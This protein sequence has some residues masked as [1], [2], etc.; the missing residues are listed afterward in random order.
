MQFAD[1]DSLA[2]TQA[3]HVDVQAF[4]D[5]GINSFYFQFTYGCSQTTTSFH[6]FSQTVQFDG[7]FHHDGLRVGD[8][9][10][11]HVQYVIF[12]GVELN[13]F[14]NGFALFAVD[15]QV[16]GIDVRRINQIAQFVVCYGEGQC[17]W[18]T[19][20]VFCFSI[21]VT[22]YGVSF[23]DFTRSLFAE[24]SSCCTFYINFFHYINF[25]VLL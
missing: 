6:T 24:C 4:G 9:I 5:I 14:Q 23:T 20:F 10:K 11:I 18:C 17:D 13:F 3:R 1:F 25:F 21:Q 2:Q 19:V 15:V 22:G 16:Y 7:H 8:F 12:Y